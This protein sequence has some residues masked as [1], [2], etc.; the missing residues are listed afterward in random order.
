MS[1]NKRRRRYYATSTRSLVCG[2]CLKRVVTPDDS[3]F[4]AF[5]YLDVH[6]DCLIDLDDNACCPACLRNSEL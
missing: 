6:N 1:K 2:Y 3:F 4:C 5:C